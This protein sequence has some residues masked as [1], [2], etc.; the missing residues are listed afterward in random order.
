M[1]KSRDSGAITEYEKR[2]AAI[3]GDGGWLYPQLTIHAYVETIRGPVFS[4]GTA[5][6]SDIIDFIEKNHAYV[7][8]TYN[9]SFYVCRWDKMTSHG[10]KV[11]ARFQS[12]PAPIICDLVAANHAPFYAGEQLNLLNGDSQSTPNGVWTGF[13]DQPGGGHDRNVS[14]CD[15]EPAANPGNGLVVDPAIPRRPGQSGRR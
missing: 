6:T 1:R 12:S 14:A 10:Y 3:H 4:V 7:D 11:Y 9:A 5:R 15:S 2:R 13:S 8:R